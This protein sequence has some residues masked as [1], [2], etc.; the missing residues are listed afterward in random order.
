MKCAFFDTVSI[1][2]SIEKSQNMDIKKDKKS[3]DER[4]D[5]RTFASISE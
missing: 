3:K 5:F 2:N 4:F 1:S